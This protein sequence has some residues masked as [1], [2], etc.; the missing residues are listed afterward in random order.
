MPTMRG[1]LAGS[2][3]LVLLGGLGVAAQ[4]GESDRVAFPTGTFI[5]TDGHHEA[6]EFNTDG[7]CRWFS[8]RDRWSMACT[9][10]SNGNLFTEMTFDYPSGPQVPATYYWDHDGERLS[11]ELWGEDMRPSRLAS[12]ADHTYS[13]VESPR[14]AL[15]ATADFAPGDRVVTI[16]SLAP[17]AEIG[18]AAFGY[19]DLYEVSRTVAAV[20]I[21]K[22]QPI[23]PDMV[24][25]PAE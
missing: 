17:A 19:D 18:P 12:Y 16:R 20:P 1:V 4:S 10:A 14:E 5:A 21:L 23:A 24:E 11:F 9:Y 22:G 15:L 25:M 7:T 8:P 3:I 2:V 13:L 6:V